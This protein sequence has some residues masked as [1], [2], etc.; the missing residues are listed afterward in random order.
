MTWKGPA[1]TCVSA[2]L[3]VQIY[4]D[5]YSELPPSERP[6]EDILPIRRR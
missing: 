4:L 3:L 5:Q 1:I 6:Y 2:I